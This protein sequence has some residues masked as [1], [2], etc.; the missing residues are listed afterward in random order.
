MSLSRKVSGTL[1]SKVHCLFLHCCGSGCSTV[2]LL[3][4][5]SVH[6]APHS[7]V[8][9]WL[10]L[11]CCPGNCYHHFR[12]LSIS[13]FTCKTQWVAKSPLL[14]LCRSLAICFKYITYPYQALP[15]KGT[16]TISHFSYQKT[17]PCSRIYLASPHKN[18][19]PRAILS[20]LYRAE[21]FVT[22]YRLDMTHNLDFQLTIPK[23]SCIFSHKDKYFINH[24]Q[25]SH[26]KRFKIWSHAI[27]CCLK[28]LAPSLTAG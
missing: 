12:I 15:Q 1:V 8:L 21:N 13:F 10:H 2:D 24:F 19:T 20:H 3:L 4:L 9:Q 11:C 27:C 26:A 23:L 14:C 7:V 25:K 17:V 22:A 18:V 16:F 28:L 6:S 5:L